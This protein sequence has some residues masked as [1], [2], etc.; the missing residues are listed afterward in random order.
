MGT[1]PG[2]TDAHINGGR[3]TLFRGHRETTVRYERFHSSCR[4]CTCTFECAALAVY[5]YITASATR[6][7]VVHSWASLTCTRHAAC[8]AVLM[9]VLP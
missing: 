8:S 5:V 6:A 2:A 1:A 7:E 3:A 4:P 9:R